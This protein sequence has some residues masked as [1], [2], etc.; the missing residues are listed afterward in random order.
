MVA[1]LT[2]P[3]LYHSAY[4]AIFPSETPDT[5]SFWPLIH[6]LAKHGIYLLEDDDVAVN[7]SVL[8]QST[9]FRKVLWHATLKRSHNIHVS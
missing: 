9:P 7:H 1:L 4:R 6:G 8:A 5:T 3:V 2:T